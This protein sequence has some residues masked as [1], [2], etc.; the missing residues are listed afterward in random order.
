M[1]IFGNSAVA[2]QQV[3]G[4]IQRAV[5]PGWWKVKTEQGHILRVASAEAWRKGERVA[6]QGRQIVGSAGKRPDP[7][8]Y[9]V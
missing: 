3:I 1:N 9:E 5:L 8:R 6:I 2:E 7:V 4:T